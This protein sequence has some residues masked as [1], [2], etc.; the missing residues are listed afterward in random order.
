MLDNLLKNKKLLL[1]FAGVLVV[2]IFVFILLLPSSSSQESED[3]DTDS[4][5]FE[6]SE[7][8]ARAFLEENHPITNLLPIIN[9]AEGYCIDYELLEDNSVVIEI[10]YSSDYGKTSADLRLKEAD[11]KNFDLNSYKITYTES[12]TF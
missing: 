4:S 9:R 12:S 11:F 2:L 5:A 10:I 7:A 8:E 3:Y 6:T 1:I